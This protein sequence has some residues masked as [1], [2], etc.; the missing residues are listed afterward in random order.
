MCSFHILKTPQNFVD[1]ILVGTKLNLTLCVQMIF[2]GVLSEM[3]KMQVTDTIWISGW[4]DPLFLFQTR[5]LISTVM[6][7]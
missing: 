2:I 3:N 1:N 6:Q 5:R 7:Q 4:N